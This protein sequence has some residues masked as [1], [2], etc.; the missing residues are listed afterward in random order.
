MK[1]LLS[2]LVIL[3]LAVLVV[4]SRGSEST[5]SPSRE[6]FETGRPTNVDPVVLADLSVAPDR[7]PP[8]PIEADTP[9]GPQEVDPA[10]VT[11]DVESGPYS[12][13]FLNPLSI[14]KLREF[15]RLVRAEQKKAVRAFK[16]TIEPSD[17]FIEEL[18]FLDRGLDYGEDFFL[19]VRTREGTKFYHVDPDRHP[20]LWMWRDRARAVQEAPAYG[21]WIEER[22][23][24]ML[25]TVRQNPGLTDY[26]IVT[27][28]SNDKMIV[29]AT[30]NGVRRRVA[31]QD[32]Q[33]GY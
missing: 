5:S 11:F 9:G 22:R 26:E 32:D 25:E 15:R 14:D 23:T 7:V 12:A 17:P 27:S 10:D 13:E 21:A 29:F 24:R 2:L 20:D 16:D 8:K 28:P 19:P 31:E 6:G 30:V 3:A 4:V 1:Q 33:T 18:D